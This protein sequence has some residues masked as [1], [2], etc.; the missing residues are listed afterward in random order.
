MATMPRTDRTRMATE[1]IAPGPSVSTTRST[2]IVPRVV[3]RLIPSRSP[4]VVAPHQLA[5]AGRQD[6]VG[7]V[8][9][10]QRGEHDPNGTRAIG[11]RRPRQRTA[12]R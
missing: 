8:A 3:E 4:E 2:T 1:A 7:Q 11:A 6:V 9:H 5:Q 10:E 12:R